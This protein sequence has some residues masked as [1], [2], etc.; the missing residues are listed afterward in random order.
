MLTRKKITENNQNMRFAK[1]LISIGHQK[2]DAVSILGF[3]SKEWFVSLM[4]TIGASGIGCGIY[5]TNLPQ[6][7]AYVIEHSESIVVTVEDDTQRA[8]IEEVLAQLPK[9]KCIVQWGGNLS[10]LPKETSCP[11]EGTKQI[12]VYTWDAWMDL[13]KDVSQSAVDARIEDTN[14]GECCSLI[15]TSGTTGPPKAVMISHD[16][17]VW[18]C[19]AGENCMGGVDNDDRIISYLPLSHIAAQIMDCVTPVLTG[20]RIYFALPDALKGT[21]AIQLQA[22]RP[23][24]FFGVPRVWEK[25]YEKMMQVAKTPAKNCKER[26]IKKIAKWAKGQAFRRNLAAQYGCTSRM[27]K[28]RYR[29]AHKILSKVHEKLGLDQCRGCFTGAAPIQRQILDYFASIDLPIYEIFGQSECSGPHTMNYPGYWKMGTCGQPL[30][31]TETRIDK[32]TGELQY[33]GRHIFMGY[34]KNAEATSSTISR[35]GWL[36]SGDQ[37]KLDGD[38]FLS[39]TGRLKELI[40]TAGGENIPPVLIE[41]EM[42]KAMEAVSQVMVVGEAKKF[43]SMFLTVKVEV[44]DNM[45]PTEM[46]TSDSLGISEAIGSTARTASEVVTCSKWKEYFDKGMDAAN[47]HTTSNAQKVQKWTLLT[48]DFSIDG[49]ELTPTMKLKRPVVL[50]MYDAEVKKMYGE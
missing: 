8:K 46:L 6:A 27:P 21:L 2:H 47:K 32:D 17:A 48:Q 38:H 5:T 26:Q 31:G 12:P 36:C 25:I 18:T 22:I 10:A 24:T 1:S 49:G 7:C 43:L 28:R 16:N 39:I 23:T 44:D 4:G 15:Y 13:G 45:K 3:N 37:A 40:I 20:L 42:K 29:V 30:R 34:L 9:L 33:R 50:K 41:D 14:P 11:T 35:E 19:H